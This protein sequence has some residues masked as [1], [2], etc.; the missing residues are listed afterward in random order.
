MRKI[1][2]RIAEL[3]LELTQTERQ[4]QKYWAMWKVLRKR[5]SELGAEIERLEKE[6]N[7]EP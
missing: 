1:K 3:K 2:G 7:N 5:T 4:A 6:V